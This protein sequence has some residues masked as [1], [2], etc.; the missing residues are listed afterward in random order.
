MPFDQYVLTP[1]AQ[2]VISEAAAYWQAGGL[3]SVTVIGHA[4]FFESDEGRTSPKYAVALSQ[5]RAKAVATVLSGLGVPAAALS[6]DG[7]GQSQA[8]GD[9]SSREPLNRRVTIDL[10]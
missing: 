2:S 3:S 7:K 10:R 1:E 8:M 6:F 9:G 4:D 5:R